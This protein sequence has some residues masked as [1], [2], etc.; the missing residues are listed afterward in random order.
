MRRT[1]IILI[2]LINGEILRIDIRLQFG[3]KR[4]ANA[5][6]AVPGYAAEEGV[7]FDFVGAADAAEAVF[8]VADET[9][10]YC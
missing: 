8:S 3:F 9:V 2:N 6:E 1:R 7:L 5:A 4:R 10:M